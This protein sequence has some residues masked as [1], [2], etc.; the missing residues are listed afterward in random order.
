[1]QIK[2]V[3]FVNSN[4]YFWQ[5]LELFWI[6]ETSNLLV[7]DKSPNGGKHCQQTKEDKDTFCCSWWRS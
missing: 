2:V 4:S 5:F 7:K 6:L 3:G 1:M